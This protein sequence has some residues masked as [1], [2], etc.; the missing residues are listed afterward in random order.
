VLTS[1]PVATC[2][3]VIGLLWLTTL[4]NFGSPKVTGRIGSVTVR[5]VILPVGFISVAGSF[6][7]HSDTFAAAWNAERES[8]PIRPTCEQVVNNPEA[9]HSTTGRMR[10]GALFKQWI[11]NTHSISLL[12]LTST[13]LSAAELLSSA[14]SKTGLYDF[15]PEPIEDAFG[16]NVYRFAD[17]GLRPV[18]ERERYRDY[19]VHFGID[20]EVVVQ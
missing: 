3:G 1:S 6:W 7:F 15:G 11:H 5:G 20:E 17:F 4:A 18:E 8:S 9:R 12:A 19:M 2:I 13:R 16:K 14:R 10:E